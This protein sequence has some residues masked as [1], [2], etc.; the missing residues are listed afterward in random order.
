MMKSPLAALA[1][2]IG[3]S[4]TAHAKTAEEVVAELPCDEINYSPDAPKSM[5]A[6]NNAKFH[7]KIGHGVQGRVVCEVTLQGGKEHAVITASEH[8]TLANRAVRIRHNPSLFPSLT[9]ETLTL[10]DDSDNLSNRL[11]FCEKRDGLVTCDIMVDPKKRVGIRLL[12]RG[13]ASLSAVFRMRILPE[14]QLD[15]V[16]SDIDTTKSAMFWSD[17]GWVRLRSVSKPSWESYI[18]GSI[19]ESNPQSSNP[20]FQKLLASEKQNAAFVWTTRSGS[21]EDKSDDA[22]FGVSIPRLKLLG[23]YAI[24]MASMLFPK[25]TPEQ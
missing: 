18:P 4:S 17:E 12:G 7:G 13:P 14:S 10:R 6:W 25:A 19:L 22:Q 2:A 16:I 3:V 15:S 20:L 11:I 24:A 23:Q 8:F 1:L 21:A 5:E 9:L